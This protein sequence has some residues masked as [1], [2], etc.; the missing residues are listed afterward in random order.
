MDVGSTARKGLQ[1]TRQS[2]SALPGARSS[3]DWPGTGAKLGSNGSSWGCLFYMNLGQ[4]KIGSCNFYRDP[5]AL[6]HL[7]TIV[8]RETT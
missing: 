4:T 1:G 8:K 3:L 2:D 6:H 5:T 7:S